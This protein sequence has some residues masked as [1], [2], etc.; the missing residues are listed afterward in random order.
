MEAPKNGK[1]LSVLCIEQCLEQIR[2]RKVREGKG[3]YSR[4]EQNLIERS[5]NIIKDVNRLCPEGG[6]CAVLYGSR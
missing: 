2:A 1:F 6:K 4:K 5:R 3:V